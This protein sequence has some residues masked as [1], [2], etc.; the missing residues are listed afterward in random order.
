MCNLTLFACIQCAL[1]MG[2]VV[3]EKKKKKKK[4]NSIDNSTLEVSSDR[5]DAGETSSMTWLQLISFLLTHSLFVLAVYLWFDVPPGTIGND[6][7]MMIPVSSLPDRYCRASDA[8][9]ECT[10]QL[11]STSL[12][13]LGGGL[14]LQTSITENNVD[15][16]RD[17]LRLSFQPNQGAVFYR[18]PNFSIG[19]NE[20]SLS[21]RLESNATEKSPVVL[22]GSNVNLTVIN[23]LQNQGSWFHLQVCQVAVTSP[24]PPTPLPTPRPPTPAPTPFPTPSLPPTPKPTP[25]PPT[26]APTP[27]P[28]PVPTPKPPTP[29]PVPG[30]TPS[31]V[32]PPTPS[33][34]PPPTPSPVPPPT[35]APGPAPPTP[36]PGPAPPTPSPPVSPAPT[37]FP[38]GD[39]GAP[40]PEP[41]T[42]TTVEG[43]TTTSTTGASD[44][45]TTEPPP[46]ITEV[47][48]TASL[49]SASTTEAPA[50]TLGAKRQEAQPT[51]EESDLNGLR[52]S[53]VAAINGDG[54]VI[55]NAAVT[56]STQ[57]ATATYV[58]N[59]PD[60]SKTG[61][62]AADGVARLRTQVEG[63]PKMCSPS[64]A[65]CAD[66][67]MVRDLEPATTTS[68]AA[69]T[70]TS[71]GA[72]TGDSVAAPSTDD[73]LL[74]YYIIAGVGGFLLLCCIVIIIVVV[75]R[76]Q[77]KPKSADPT[78][79]YLD[80][81]QV[82][83]PP[84][85][86][87]ASRADLMIEFVSDLT[88]SADESL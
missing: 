39:T 4:K 70:T 51:I 22:F 13:L 71:G 56:S 42:T 7:Q 19:G 47:T 34:V 72:T 23:N 84:P 29:M 69:S 15:R 11:K 49:A 50:T 60:G 66:S 80:E 6:V 10:I 3:D 62:P 48:V 73:M 24:I 79:D 74:I 53:I 35:P 5:N 38:P 36:A 25:L 57:G 63:P 9:A 28:T 37:P 18:I 21:F 46:I 20:G 8:L 88:S 32:P 16:S 78:M 64:M 43:E 65:L 61:T 12:L 27:F 86:E 81:K 77:K 45:T 82:T 75:C 31:P 68:T 17:Q 58:V 26:P 54:A 83:T 30:Q 87:P 85:A 59:V 1:S 52:D 40:T 76:R 67:I 33:P 2:F 44:M 55:D 41:P 14:W